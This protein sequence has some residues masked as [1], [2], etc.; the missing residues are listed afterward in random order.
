MKK[1]LLAR[2]PFGFELRMHIW[3]RGA[4]GPDDDL[5]KHTTWHVALP[6][7]GSF[8]EKR[9]EPNDRPRDIAEIARGPFRFTGDRFRW[10]LH[11][12]FCSKKT[13]HTLAPL[14]DNPAASIVLSGRSR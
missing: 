14:D 8:V 6:L 3:P 9:F 10:P 2:L 4:E 13:I 1:H 12:Y 5:H 11:P 7:W